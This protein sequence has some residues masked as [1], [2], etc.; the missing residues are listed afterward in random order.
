SDR[1]GWTIPRSITVSSHV[2]SGAP[3]AAEWQLPSF[4]RSILRARSSAYCV[5]VPVLNEGRR[6][7]SLLERMR[8]LGIPKIA[9]IIIVDGGSND[10][11]VELDLLQRTGI[12]GL[13]ITEG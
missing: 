9:D 2:E 6:I 8:V 10:G 1:G 12:R 3:A 13:L 5:V 11:S 4:R 7:A